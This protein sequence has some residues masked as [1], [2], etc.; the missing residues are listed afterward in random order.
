MKT[1]RPS[2]YPRVP[3][4]TRL[5]DGTPAAAAASFTCPLIEDTGNGACNTPS[6]RTLSDRK[7]FLKFEPSNEK[8]KTAGMIRAKAACRQFRAEGDCLRWISSHLFEVR[9]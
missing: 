2:R 7:A 1:L 3:I 4:M 5:G 8:L 6:R 9:S